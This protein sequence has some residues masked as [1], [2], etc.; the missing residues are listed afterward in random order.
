MEV[1]GTISQ[2]L[3]QYL[4]NIPEKDEIKKLQKKQP[5]WTCIHL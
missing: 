5:Y 4:S 3:R 2:S 1:I